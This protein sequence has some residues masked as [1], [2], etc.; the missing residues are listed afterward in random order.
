MSTILT[1]DEID[2]S[3]YMRETDAQAKVKPASTWLDDLK[4]R[5]TFKHKEKKIYLPWEKTRDVFDF[6]KGEVTVWAGQNGHGK[7]MMTTQVVLSLMG[8]EQK[9]CVAS[10]EMKPVMTMQRMARMYCGCNPFLPEFQGNEGVGAVKSLYDEFAGW[11]D[12]RLWIY[13]QQGTAE[14]DRVLGMVRY[15]AKELGIDHVFVDNLGKCVKNEDDYNAQKA[16]VDEITAIARD[17]EVH[18]HI[19]HHLKK[20]NKETTRPDKHDTK[21]SGAITDQP[22][23]LFLVWRNKEKEL[24]VKAKGDRSTK[25]SEPDQYLICAKQR[26]YEG[27]LDD[28]PTVALWYDRDSM[29]YVSME[30]DSPLFFPN[31]PHRAT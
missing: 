8:Q 21:G 28:E 7:S 2:F 22:D 29:Q 20:P 27:S 13:D 31:Y 12:G 30:G 4:D 11:T 14:T 5:L 3:L 25:Q 1:G 6:R 18:V 19:V 23:N 9:V 10:F 16:F 17:N 26:N 24:D 15:C